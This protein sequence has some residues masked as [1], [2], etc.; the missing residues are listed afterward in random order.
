MEDEGFIANFTNWEDAFDYISR[1][2]SAKRTVLI[3]DEF[4]FLAGPNPTIK[5][6]L[7]HKI[8]RDWKD[9]NIFIILCGSSVSFMI[10][11]IMGYESPLYGRITGTMEVKAFDYWESREFFPK[12]DPVDQLIA[13]GILGGVPRYLNA[14]DPE[15]S[16][17]ENIINEILKTGS[18]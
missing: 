9:K 15:K 14:F 10:N 11:D 18:F 6:I 16:L 1:K 4:P 7:Q 8:D 12:Y 5:S 3:I 2:M 17:R 13:Y